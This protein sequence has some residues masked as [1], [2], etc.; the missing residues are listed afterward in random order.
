[1]NHLTQNTLKLAVA[2]ALAGTS[3]NAAAIIDFTGGTSDVAVYASE[4]PTTFTTLAATGQTFSLKLPNLSNDY[5]V[6]GSN[7]YNVKVQ[8]LNGAKFGADVTTPALYCDTGAGSGSLVTM[9]TPTVGGAGFSNAT[10]VVPTAT[11]LNG[12]G[13]CMVSG[14]SGAADAI[15]LSGISTK[16][17]SAL[18]EFKDGATPTTTGYK[19]NLITFSTA[20]KPVFTP[21]GNSADKIIDVAK[22]TLKY[23]DDT[24]TATL[25]TV[26]FGTTTAVPLTDAPADAADGNPVTGMKA[27]IGTVALS[28][29]SLTLKVSGA[30]VGGATQVTLD[31]TSACSAPIATATISGQLATFGTAQTVSDYQGGVVAPGNSSFVCIVHDGAT[32]IN[33]GKVTACFDFNE[34]GTTVNLQ[35]PKCGELREVK[36]NGKTFYGYVIPRS[37]EAAV[38]KTFFRFYN[39]STTEGAIRVTLYGQDG[40]M[41][42]SQGQIVVEAASFQPNAVAVVNVD[43]ILLATSGIAVGSAT[44]SEFTGRAHAVFDIEL[45]DVEMISALRASSGTLTNFSTEAMSH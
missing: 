15:T 13:I 30:V 31:T 16:Q 10:F 39:K 14:I 12:G 3:L 1:M 18:I 42:G 6:G 2:A 43:D 22:Q 23:A 28:G 38:D 19:S 45:P 26:F 35:L 34:E 9:S 4:N 36:K 40:T 44:G 7:Y 20:L 21:A 37:G 27:T 32:T 33:S 5:T 11:T 25:G 17:V 8:L 24:V 29:L 41:I